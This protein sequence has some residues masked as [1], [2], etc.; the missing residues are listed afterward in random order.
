MKL[1]TAC[2]IGVILNS[3]ILSG[4]AQEF[5]FDDP[6][7]TFKDSL[8]NPITS[9]VAMAILS[10]GSISMRTMDY[11]NGKKEITLIPISKKSLDQKNLEDKNWI[12][13][14]TNAKMPEFKLQNM[15]GELLDNNSLL[16]RY[17]V[18]NFW[19]VGCK[20]C[21]EEMPML[22]KLVEK[23]AKDSVLFLAPALDS[24]VSIEKMLEKREFAYDILFESKLLAQ[25]MELNSYPAHLIL[26]KEGRII[27][28][29]IGG[30]TDIFSK[31]DL[32]LNKVMTSSE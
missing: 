16:G 31:L 12:E 13:K 1:F 9:K 23:Y 18:I 10:K 11:G 20:P 21:I 30:S 7:I 5:K 15:N 26:N 32:L 22:N 27:E 6:N 19:F 25:S 24:K 3:A 17:T 14:W 28:I 8:G 4:N 2:I 29:L